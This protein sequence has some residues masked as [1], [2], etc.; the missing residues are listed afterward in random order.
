MS[1]A[2]AA[3][4]YA[5]LGLPV[6]PLWPPVVQF[7]GGFMC[8]CGRLDCDSPAK[9]PHGRIARNGF[10]DASTNEQRVKSFWQARADCNIGIATGA[11]TVLD[12]DPR[13]GGD[14]ALAELEAKH[15]ALPATWRV[16]TGG[17]GQHI[18]FKAPTKIGNSANRLAQGIDVRGVGG[19][20]VAPPS[21]HISGGAYTWI[22]GPDDAPLAL[23]PSWI[24]DAL[25]E[26]A[27]S[28]KQMV[29]PEAW[30]KLIRDGVGE[31]K[32]NIAIARLV[33]HLLARG[34]DPLVALDLCRCWNMVRCR[35]P[36]A[37][38]E[39]IRTVNSIAGREFNKRE[40]S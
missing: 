36:L 29:L 26:P 19:Y 8:G 16:A 14:A 40:A 9:H 12:I 10:K 6:F 15:G 34:I 32:R 30:Q 31:G 5:R 27:A 18:Y 24:V 39:V 22:T 28:N 33:G 2:A 7:S 11:V 17:G 13:H 37:E 35:P 20:V 23:L 3:L 4:I 21:Q 38:A 1:N 25:K